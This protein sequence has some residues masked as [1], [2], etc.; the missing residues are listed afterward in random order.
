MSLS[1]AQRFL[2]G[3]LVILVAGMAGIGLWVSRQIEGRVIQRTAATTALYVDSLITS[4]LQGL[5]DGDTVSERGV[6]RLN[7]LLEDTPMGQEVVNF[8]VWDAAGRIVYSTDPAQV[9]QTF[10]VDAELRSAWEGGVSAEMGLPEGGIGGVDAATDGDLLEIYS[11]VRSS[12]TDEVIAVAEFY[13]A[14]DD[15]QGELAAA[16]RRSWLVV[17][18]VAVVTYLL[19]A[20]FVQRASNTIDRQQRALA[21]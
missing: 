4:S 6:K 1:L 15:L 20:V 10:P 18:G 21:A 5:A 3:S 16:Q 8:R 11:P 13:Y 2:L 19:L 17:G 14:A 12:D 9:G 7:W